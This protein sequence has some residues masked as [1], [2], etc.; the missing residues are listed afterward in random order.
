MQTKDHWENL[1]VKKGEKSVSWF[2]QHALTSLEIIRRTTA[3]K[4]A[5]IVD[6]GG[7]AS[8][9]V[10]DLLGEGYR[11]LTV[12]DISAAALHA[13][14][15]RLGGNGDRV[16]WIEADIT[17]AVLPARHYDVWHDRAVFHFLTDP[18]ARHKY[19]EAVLHAVKPGGQVIVATFGPN[20]PLR[21]SGL[22]TVRYSPES[23][24][25]EFGERFLLIEHKEEA[26]VTPSGAVQQ[27]IY[28]YCRKQD[29]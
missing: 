14:K 2:Q 1:Y 16:N 29:A 13:S 11:E 21:C 12:L 22:P 19:V 24:H 17:E 3:S 15:L 25:D 9:L 26:H 5:R 8:T 7:G 10:D 4:S 18:E 6:V 27:F 23:L 20:G 28:C